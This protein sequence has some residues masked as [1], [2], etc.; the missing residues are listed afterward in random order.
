MGAYG[1]ATGRGMIQVHP[2]RIGASVGSWDSGGG[3]ILSGKGVVS[4][5]IWPVVHRCPL[6]R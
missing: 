5:W 6:R 3:V 2:R 1:G 4:G